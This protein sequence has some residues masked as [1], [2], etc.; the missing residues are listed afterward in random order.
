MYARISA[1]MVPQ[2]ERERERE[3]MKNAT[4]ADLG[5]NV[6][7]SKVASSKVEFDNHVSSSPASLPRS[8]ANNLR[9][10]TWTFAR[11]IPYVP[12]LCYNLLGPLQGSFG[13]FGPEIPKKSKKSSRGLSALGS[14]KG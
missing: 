14:K 9:E 7:H 8:V 2:T 4:T 13:P 3:R 10:L 6:Q 11:L 12:W 5:E 1:R